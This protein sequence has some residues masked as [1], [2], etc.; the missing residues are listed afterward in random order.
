MLFAF[1][2][3]R[4]LTSTYTVGISRGAKYGYTHD[5]RVAGKEILKR[6]FGMQVGN[7][8]TMENITE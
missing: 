7:T 8:I 1:R 6:I 3:I 4:V 5:L 2:S